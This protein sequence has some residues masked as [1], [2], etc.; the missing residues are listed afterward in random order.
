MWLCSQQ[1]DKIKAELCFG[2]PCKLSFLKVHV[3]NLSPFFL[4]HQILEECICTSG[5]TFTP[6]CAILVF[7]LLN[8][9][10]VG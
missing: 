8:M 3:I 4:G 10:I 7:F 2:F 6:F 9:H 1:G 5:K